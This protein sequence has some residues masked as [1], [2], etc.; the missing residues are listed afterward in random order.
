MASK[1]KKNKVSE[2]NLDK[3]ANKL[4]NPFGKWK[5]TWYVLWGFLTVA[6]EL[7]LI[8]IIKNKAASPNAV[9]TIVIFISIPFITHLLVS[10]LRKFLYLSLPEKPTKKAN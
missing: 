8:F 5:P 7:V 4:V 6:G 2:T 10:G 3:D 1:K 9:Q